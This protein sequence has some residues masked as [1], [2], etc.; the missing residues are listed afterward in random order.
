MRG[1]GAVLLHED[2]GL[3]PSGMN[4]LMYAWTAWCTG[5]SNPLAWDTGMASHVQQ[6]HPMPCPP[7][8]GLRIL[9]FRSG[10][11][12]MGGQHPTSQAAITAARHFKGQP[13][14]FNMYSFLPGT[15]GH[16]ND[17]ECRHSQAIVVQPR[18]LPDPCKRRGKIAQRST[19]SISAGVAALCAGGHCAGVHR[20]APG[21]RRGLRAPEHRG[22]GGEAVA[23]TAVS[24]GAGQRAGLCVHR[25]AGRQ[26]P[27]PRLGCSF[28][29][30]SVCLAGAARGHLRPAVKQIY[31]LYAVQY[32]LSRHQLYAM[33][34]LRSPLCATPQAGSLQRLLLPDWVATRGCLHAARC[35]RCAAV[36]RQADRGRP[37]WLVLKRAHIP[38]LCIMRVHDHCSPSRLQMACPQ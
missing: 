9:Q 12:G 7:H 32:I 26:A 18:D 3:H 28:L 6:H 21:Y 20:A 33:Q 35:Q 4:S 30:T 13:P 37:A 22:P 1:W 29:W 23:A 36:A 27:V 14:T 2:R 19:S 24:P 5:V 8:G 10:A 16:T 25:A 31:V 15:V 11:V 38:A 34:C 17:M